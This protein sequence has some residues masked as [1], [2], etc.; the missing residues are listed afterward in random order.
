[1]IFV[2]MKTF[3]RMG[4]AISAGLL[5]TL[6]AAAQSDKAAI[7][8]YVSLYDSTTR[9]SITALGTV[10]LTQVHPGQPTTTM[11]GTW[12]YKPSKGKVL[13]YFGGNM[14]RQELMLRKRG[15]LGWTL[16]NPERRL[17]YAKR[18]LNAGEELPIMTS[19]Y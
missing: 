14:P 12:K 17:V 9:I 18:R 13:I 11:T 5:M 8:D 7:G 4:L 1:M 2:V 3:T 15:E 16:N 6:S 19:M 10:T